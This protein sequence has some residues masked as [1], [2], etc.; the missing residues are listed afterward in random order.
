MISSSI[1]ALLLFLYISFLNTP[2]PIPKKKERIVKIAVITPPAPPKVEPKPVI[3]PPK[4][5]KKKIIKKTKPKPKP[6]PKKKIIK[7]SKP[8]PKPKP[9]K[10]IIKKSK[11]KP[12]HKPKKIKP[13]P[14]PKPVEEEVYKEIVEEI[15][16][17]PIKRVKPKPVVV[18]QTPPPT[19]K[20]DLSAHKQ[21]FKDRARASIIA[22]KKYPRIA[23][24][25]RIQGTVHVVF[26][27]GVDGTATN[28]RTSGAS[29]LLQKA[30]KRSIQKSFP[31]D[32][33]DIIIGEFPMRNVSINIDFILE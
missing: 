25:R 22:N 27:I 7:K 6:K 21:R 31:I 32:I 15:Y 29:N 13:K 4:P 24:R 18:K 28:I 33:P 5:K 11:P 26:D 20:V 12:K 3:V 23:K 14:I 19:P 9:K 2:K 17:E 30:T 8:K 10:K 1:Y 16:Q